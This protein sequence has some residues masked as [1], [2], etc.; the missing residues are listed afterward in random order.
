MIDLQCE[1]ATM[2]ICDFKPEE[3]TLGL[4]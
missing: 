4:K 2:R 3:W 1:C